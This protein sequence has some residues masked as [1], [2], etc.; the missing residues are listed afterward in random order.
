MKP[1]HY[2][3]TLAMPL[4]A[5]VDETRGGK[6]WKDLRISTFCYDDAFGLVFFLLG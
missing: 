4:G 5:Q 3:H 6:F 1:P 2:I